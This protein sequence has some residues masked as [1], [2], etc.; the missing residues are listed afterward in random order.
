MKRIP[1]SVQVRQ[2][3]T[4]S[5]E[6]WFAG[7]PLRQFVARAAELMLQVDGGI[8][9][10][11]CTLTAGVLTETRLT[12]LRG[13]VTT[14]RFNTRGY[15]IGGQQRPLFAQGEE[16]VQVRVVAALGGPSQVAC[17]TK[18]DRDVSRPRNG[19]KGHGLLVFC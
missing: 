13:H 15:L 1:P 11:A 7:H 12:N 16:V 10:F 6:A 3:L 17:I 9:S 5:L 18:S 8:S 19:Y 4:E 14:Y 2:A